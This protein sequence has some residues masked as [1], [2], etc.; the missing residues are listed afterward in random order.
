MTDTACT[1]GTTS[2]V[3][4]SAFDAS[5]ITGVFDLSVI[6]RYNNLFLTKYIADTPHSTINFCMQVG[7]LP[8]PSRKCTYCKRNL[9]LVAENRPANKT[10]VVYRCCNRGCRHYGKYISVKQDT[11]FDN[12]H[13]TFE[14]V[15]RLIFLYI[16]NISTYE[17]LQHECYD[18][19][20]QQ[21]ST[22]TINDWL[23]Y[24]REIQL[25]ALIRHSTGEIGGENLTVEI[26]EAKFGKRKYNRGR[27]VEGQ[28]VVG[29]ICRETDE[30]FVALCP[31]NKRDSQTLLTII[32][33]HVDNRSTVITD[34]WK[35]YDQLEQD[36]WQHLRVN[37]SHNFVDPAT[38]AHTQNIENTWW[39][40]KRNLPS[41]HAGRGGNLM[42]HFADYLWRRKFKGIDDH[43][44]LT[45]IRHTAELYP[46]RQ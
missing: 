42:L 7:L 43:L 24:F 13:L 10:P 46:G 45:F 6:K 22:S 29:G 44:C 5:L 3:A 28:W 17:Q 9:N 36:N 37:H 30:I 32:E 23:T 4:A 11:V 19:S 2:A 35:A 34:C 12:T 40:L 8:K 1:S 39:Q 21:L 18:E 38:G 41:T 31:D 15:L 16:A 25:E 33:Q 20:E 27:A 14:T 26:D